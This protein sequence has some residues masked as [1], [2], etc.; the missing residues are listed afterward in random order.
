MK[1]LDAPSLTQII[2]MDELNRK[3]L[4]KKI[5]VNLKGSLGGK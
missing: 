2:V 5:A 4:E 1:Q 3:E